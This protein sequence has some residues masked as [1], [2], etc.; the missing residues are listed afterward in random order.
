M[1]DRIATAYGVALDNYAQGDLLDLGCG[2][3]PLYGIYRDHV[4]STVCADWPQTLHRSSHIDLE[5][6]LTGSLPF[7]SS[8]FDTVLLT[9]VLEHLPRPDCVWAELQRVLR[10]SGSLILGVPFLYWIHEAPHDY[11]RYTEHRLKLFCAEYGFRI[12]E[13]AAYGGPID[14]L[15]DTLAKALHHFPSLRWAVPPLLGMTSVAGDR[16]KNRV[17]PMPLGYLLVA[18]RCEAP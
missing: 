11:Y 16:V 10:V 14:V 5:I 3:V 6:D 17:T 15:G 4:K 8:S 12:L 13:L 7:V 1:A 2:H 9:D 18:Q